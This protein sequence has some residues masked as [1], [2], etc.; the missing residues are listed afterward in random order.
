M[1]ITPG[2][3]RVFVHTGGKPFDAGK[4]V[5]LPRSFIQPGLEAGG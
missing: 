2:G 4:P 1:Q 5:T 3:R